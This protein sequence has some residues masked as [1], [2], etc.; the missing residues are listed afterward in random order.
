MNIAL[1][2][3][4]VL[5]GVFFVFHSFVMLRPSPG[6]MKYILEMPAGLRLSVRLAHTVDSETAAVG[7]AISASVESDVK[8]KGKLPVPQGAILRGRIRQLDSHAIPR[9][10]H[11]IGLEF[12]D[13][14]FPGHHA[15][16]FGEME[17]IGLPAALMEDM[18]SSQTRVE[19]SV[20]GHLQIV[21]RVERETY[22][23]RQVP[24]VSTF[25]INGG[26]LILPEGLHMTWRTMN[27][28]K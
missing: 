24:G 2:V 12:T 19:G 25:S 21:K 3:L 16:F 6:G 23:T 13:L 14:E 4:Q 15:R 26:R 7:D 28:T 8:Q 17:Y 22:W 27:L 9:E 18:T 20:L 11:V 1:W 10:Y 5:L